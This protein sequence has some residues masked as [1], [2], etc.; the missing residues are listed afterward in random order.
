MSIDI[1]MGF[2]YSIGEDGHFKI[3]DI[4]SKHDNAPGEEAIFDEQLSSSGL[5]VLIHQN[6]KFYIGDGQG[7][8]YIYSN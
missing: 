3:T 5:K 2:L 1:P 6:D 4:N 8:V 7:F